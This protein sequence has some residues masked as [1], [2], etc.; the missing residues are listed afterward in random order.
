MQNL[1]TL[2]RM[3][4][5]IIAIFILLAAIMTGCSLEG[6][7]NYTPQILIPFYPKLQ[8]GDSLPIFGTDQAD[9]FKVD[10]ITVGDTVSIYLYMTSFENNLTAFYL[11]QSSDSA[12]SL[13]LPSK[14]S[15]DSI[16][17]ATSDYKNGNFLMKG[18]SNALY[19]P[20][21]FV[22]KKASG[23]TKLVFTTTSDAKFDNASIGTNYA[24][25][26]L[27]TPIKSK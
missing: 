11:K 9:V 24:T 18:N 12:T 8:N 15:M 23:E 26:T 10:T 17:L 16:F 22:A 5:R 1:Q 19:F 7:S 13:I 4:T 14:A 21:K 2:N 3:K 20:F 27:K 25:F 6:E